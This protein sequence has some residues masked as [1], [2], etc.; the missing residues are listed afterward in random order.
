MELVIKETGRIKEETH[1]REPV[2]KIEDGILV[3]C[4]LN[5]SKTVT[6]P[7][8]VKIIDQMCFANTNVEEV[9]LPEGIECIGFRAFANC[10]ELKRINF[11]ETLN[12]IKDRAFMNCHSLTEAILP[13]TLAELGDLAFYDAG[14]KQLVLPKKAVSTGASVFSGIKIKTIDIPEKFKLGKS[15]FADCVNLHTVNFEADGATIPERCFYRR[16]CSTR[17]CD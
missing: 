5:G 8:G 1:K 12:V 2:F 7:A 11:P 9:I 10:N 3:D 16:S 14:I 4:N 13:E 6:I 15:M 17:W